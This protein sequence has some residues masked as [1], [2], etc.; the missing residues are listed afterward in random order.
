MGFLIVQKQRYGKK[1][2]EAVGFRLA[3]GMWSEEKAEVVRRG[4][5]CRRG[6]NWAPSFVLRQDMEML[7][8]LVARPLASPR[9]LL[10]FPRV[11]DIRDRTAG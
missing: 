1:K 7:S 9:S 11:D 10:A 6:V 3:E 8:Y 5:V 4:V 2:P